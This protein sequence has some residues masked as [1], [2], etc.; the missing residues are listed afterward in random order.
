MEIRI[1]ETKQI[2]YLSITDPKTGC[3]WTVDLIGSHGGEFDYDYDD[4]IY[5]MDQDNF[6]WWEDLIERYQSAD[7]KYHEIKTT[8]I[9]GDELEAFIFDSRIPNSVELENYPEAL[10]EAINVWISEQDD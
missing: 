3:D 6:N 2:K 10:I 1:N 9:K 5:T 7:N 8:H 4:N